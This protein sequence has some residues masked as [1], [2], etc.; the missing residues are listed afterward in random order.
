[1]RYVITH[2][3]DTDEQ[4]FWD[5][6]F[7]DEFNDAL[8]IG[9]L[10]FKA[11]RVLSFERQPDGRITKRT[12]AAPAVEL[13]STVKKVVGD[14]TSY[15]EAGE[16][17]PSTRRYTVDVTPGAAADKVK[18]RVQIWV[19]ARGDKRVDRYVEVDNT[20]RIFGVGKVVEKFIEQQTRD[21]Y[22]H[23]AEFTNRWIKEKGL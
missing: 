9:H 1:M 4:T 10:K 7:D 6:F 8:F 3:I 21:T 15:V 12:E 19:E 17:D 2:S 5:L 20:V 18:T 13:P 16:F 22:T 14:V 23:V 11:H